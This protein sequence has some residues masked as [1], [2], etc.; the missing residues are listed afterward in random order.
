MRINKMFTAVSLLFIVATSCT[1]DTQS[2]AAGDSGTGTGG[3]LARFTIAANH[4]YIADFRSVTVFDLADPANPVKK[5]T[6]QVAFPVETIFPLGD[7]LFIGSVNGMFIYS[8]ANPS[9]PSLVGSATHARSCDPVVANDS[10]AYVTLRGGTR[11]GPAQ[12][13]LYIYDIKNVMAP[14]Q[15]SLVSLG[16]PYGLGIKD[17][18]VFVCRGQQGLTAVNVKNPAMPSV[19]YTKQDAAYFDVIPYNNLLICYVESGI[20]MYDISNLNQIA[21]L[22]EVNY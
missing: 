8:I 12:D 7:K 3:S 21:K 15:K 11:C 4:L 9:Q 1:K 22:G 17:S 19:M 6:V 5:T 14:V 16:N 2:A 10:V 13:G 20:I 18:V